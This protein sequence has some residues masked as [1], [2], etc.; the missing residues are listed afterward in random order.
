MEDAE[1]SFN[2]LLSARRK[3]ITSA[4]F[5]CDDSYFRSAH[6]FGEG[7]RIRC[8]LAQVACLKQYA[9]GFDFGRTDGANEHSVRPNVRAKR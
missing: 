2:V 8:T 9:S 5:D 1:V 6:E 4:S 3:A 7:P